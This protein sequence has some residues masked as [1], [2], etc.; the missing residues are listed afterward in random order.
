[1]FADVNNQMR[2][3]REE[4]FGPVLVVIPFEDENDAVNIANDSPFGLGGSIFTE[5]PDH[6]AALARRIESGSVG[7][8]FYGSNM[9]APFGGWKDSG[10]GMEYG[11]EAIGA[12]T[13][14]K[15]I[16]RQR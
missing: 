16:H 14:M 9:G 2:V 12:Y 7:I 8:N 1:V 3:A 11:P 5:D 4:I 6:G 10:I 13:R 15:S